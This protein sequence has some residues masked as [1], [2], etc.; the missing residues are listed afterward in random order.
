MNFKAVKTYRKY[1]SLV[2]SVASACLL[3]LSGCAHFQPRGSYSGEEVSVSARPVSSQLK[4]VL[5]HSAQD[6]S[7]PRT[8]QKILVKNILLQN[9]SFD[10]PVVINS[11]VEH[12]VDYFCGKGRV[13]F[14]KYLERSEYFIPYI[15]P[16]LKQNHLPEDLVYLAMIESGFNNLARSHAKAVG[17]WQFISSTGRNY[18]LQVNWWID[19][20]RDIQ[21]S[22]LAAAEYLKNLYRIFQ[23]WELA[24]AAYNAGESKIAR[25]VRR[26]GEKDFWVI[27]RHRFLRQETRDYIP[28]MIAA[29]LISKNRAQFG[30][31]ESYSRPLSD[32]VVAA[33]GELVK[34]VA[35]EK[36]VPDDEYQQEKAMDT[37]NGPVESYTY[38]SD[39]ALEEPSVATHRA[40]AEATVVKS[41]PVPHLAKDGKVGGENLV[42]FEVQSPADML[43]IARAAGLSYHTV[44]SLNP[45]VLRW[46]T[47]PKLPTFRIK[48]PAFVKDR[49]LSAYHHESFPRKV[50]FMTYHAKKGDSLVRIARHFG[51]HIDSVTGLNSFSAK[52]PLKNG[53]PVV[54]PMPDN[55]S[56]SFASLDLRDPPERKKYRRVSLRSRR[57]PSSRKRYHSIS[58]KHRQV[59][60]LG[61]VRSS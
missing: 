49:F 18:G 28:K 29:A 54:L 12:W 50:E 36:P 11:K 10:I 20:R 61:L 13:Y 56:R 1:R 17:P 39:S 42:E 60:R 19:E 3:V 27:A 14:S 4:E 55:D 41:V 34:L 43:K 5:Q 21:K 25:A 33:D 59:S 6:L 57:G 37:Q 7:V 15:V 44:K 8:N 51:I 46:C 23:S 35:S 47:P 48:L 31:P 45:E 26:F 30:F 38:D 9:T 52:A 32:E 58:Y 53:H 40:A 2:W 24:A 22:T 16:I